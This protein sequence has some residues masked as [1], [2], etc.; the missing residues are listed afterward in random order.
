MSDINLTRINKYLSEIGHCSRREAD[1]LI[2]QGRVKVNGNIALM[3]EKIRDEDEVSING[4]LI[5]KSAKNMV[6]IA[7]NKPPGIVCTTDTKR[8]K[9]NIK[10]YGNPE[11]NLKGKYD[12]KHFLKDHR[13]FMMSTV[14]AL[15]LGGDW[16][17]HDKNSIKTSFPKFLNIL[18]K[19]G[20]K[21]N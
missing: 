17:I 1:K 11:L 15:T 14:A 9:D 5:Q 19:L 10:V 3:G 6:Y 13:V 20:A 12:V 7:F 21:I 8:E 2:S 16:R 4:K 18:T